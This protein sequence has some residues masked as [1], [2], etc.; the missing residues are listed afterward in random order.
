MAS[1]SDVRA[2]GAFVELFTKDSKL[3]VGLR[4]AMKRVHQFAEEAR[5]V[6]V[7]A[8]V[9]GFGIA[10]GFFAAAKSFASTGVELGKLQDQTGMSAEALNGLKQ[11]AADNEVEFEPLAKSITFLQRAIANGSKETAE[12]FLQIGV[13]ADQLKGKRLEQVIGLIADRLPQ[14]EDEEKRVAIAMQLFGKNGAAMLPVLEDG[15]RGLNEAAK[16]AERLGTAFDADALRKARELDDACD[17]LSASTKGLWHEIGAAA[18]DGV[19]P[20]V[21]GIVDVIILTR[22]WIK[23]NPKAVESVMHVAFAI[24]AMGLALVA[25]AT[26]V[27]ALTSPT[28][29]ITGIFLGLATA[30]LATTDALGITKTGFGDMFNSVRVGGQGL[31]TWFAKL[32]LFLGR[33]WFRVET[34]LGESGDFI[35]T[36]FRNLGSAI[37][38]ALIWVPRALIEPFA[39]LAE[40][41]ND[42]LGT[43]IDV[44]ATLFLDKLEAEQ[45]ASRE[46]I[47]QRNKEFDERSE[48]RRQ[49]QAFADYFYQVAEAQLDA[50]DPDDGTT[51]L[52]FDPKRFIS[53]LQTLGEGVAGAARDAI[54]ALIEELQGAIKDRNF[55]R[56]A[57]VEPFQGSPSPWAV[58]ADTVEKARKIDATTTFNADIASR[59]GVGSTLDER[60]L[61]AS[62]AIERHTRAIFEELRLNGGAAYGP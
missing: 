43:E 4:S 47:A 38:E 31:A 46:A 17:S 30:L 11:R 37:Y 10:A 39:Q 45:R 19:L 49:N 26:L 60:Q 32:A 13:S 55:E 54:A 51:G 15:S 56:A 2:G 8:T 52:G 12:A 29:L 50:N 5:D 57:S 22:Q 59:I 9:G 28:I 34:F 33:T 18:A 62:E 14:L 7:R 48:R 27:Y 36:G 44:R 41:I 24:G 40:L 61:R 35:K 21:N 20:I 58:A 1:G 3:I 6:G 16:S 42:L 23:E 25:L 53:G